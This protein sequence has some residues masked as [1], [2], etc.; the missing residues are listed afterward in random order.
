M[1]HHL[2][3]TFFVIGVAVSI[4][5]LIAGYGIVGEWIGTVIAIITGLAWLFAW[6]YPS[7][8]LPFICLVVSVCLAVAGRLI[9][10]PALLMI[11]GSGFA[12]A[13]WDLVFLNNALGRDSLGVQTRQYERKHLQSLALALG[14][15]LLV[16]FLGRLFNLQLPFNTDAFCC[17]GH[18]WAGSRLW[19]Y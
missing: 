9:G 16:A 11:C 5:C 14:S 6:K 13:V 8:G 1:S 3:K 4:L 17:L 15:G 2:R 7:S 12:L 19:L 18:I 10:S